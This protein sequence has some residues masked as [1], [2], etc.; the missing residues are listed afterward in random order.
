VPNTSQSL[1]SPRFLALP[2]DA[3]SDLAAGLLT[4]PPASTFALWGAK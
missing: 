4:S 3:A 2:V 1:L